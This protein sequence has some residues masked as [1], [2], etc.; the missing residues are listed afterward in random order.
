[1]CI[2]LQKVSATISR[3]SNLYRAAFAVWESLAIVNAGKPSKHQ[4]SARKYYLLIS[5]RTSN[6][7]VINFIQRT[8]KRKQEIARKGQK[9][10]HPPH[11]PPTKE[12]KQ[13]NGQ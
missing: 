7:Q 5:V 8:E 6:N 3:L 13:N 1:V 10:Y 2:F 4:T 11:Q 9:V 12:R